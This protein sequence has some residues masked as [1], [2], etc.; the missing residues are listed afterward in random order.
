MDGLKQRL[1]SDFVPE[2]GAVGLLTLLVGLWASHIQLQLT[3][4]HG[5]LLPVALLFGATLLFRAFSFRRGGL[6]L[7]YFALSLAVS[8]AICA[9]SYL[10]LASSQTLVD[11]QLMA[12]DRALGFD[13]LA[14]Y[15]FVRSHPAL[16]AILGFAYDSLIYQGLYFGLLLGLMN[17]RWRLK[18]MFRLVLVSGSLACLGALFF[19]ALGPSKFFSIQTDTGFVPVMEHLLSGRDLSFSLSGMT[20]VI[21]FPSFHTSMALAYIWAFRKAGA[22]GWAV[23][24]LNLVMLCSVPWFGGHYLVDM[25]AGA[26]NMLLSLAVIKTAPRLWEKILDALATPKPAQ[27]AG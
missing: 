13:W 21:S 12:M 5:V 18:E 4:G 25:L 22:I 2:W 10:S 19:P 15:N 27:A 6:I 23:T 16:S 7:E 17:D 8:T 1:N 3:D 11:G 24:G 26:A 9:L 20:G 14:G